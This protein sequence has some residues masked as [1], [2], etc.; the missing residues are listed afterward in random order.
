MLG[1]PRAF[2]AAA[3][4]EDQHA[5]RVSRDKARSSQ[6]RWNAVLMR[7]DVSESPSTQTGRRYTRHI[8]TLDISLRFDI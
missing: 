8:R 2:R 4:D 5:M 6:V 3:L 1:R 7:A